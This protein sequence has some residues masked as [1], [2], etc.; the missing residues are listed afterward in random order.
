MR[1]K[2]SMMRTLGVGT[3]LALGAV[4]VARAED[5]KATIAAAD[6]QW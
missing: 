4:G 3:M 1:L 5:L 6:A 2:K